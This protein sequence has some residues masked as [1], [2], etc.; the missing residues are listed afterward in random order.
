MRP[1]PWIVKGIKVLAFGVHLRLVRTS[2][3]EEFTPLDGRFQEFPWMTILYVCLLLALV[4][5]AAI[6]GGPDRVGVI[7][8]VAGVLAGIILIILIIRRRPKS[9]SR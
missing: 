9:G 5:C 7:R 4:I 3:G 1:A 8:I 6:L 2:E